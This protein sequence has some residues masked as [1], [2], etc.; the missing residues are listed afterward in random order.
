MDAVI[1]EDDDEDHAEWLAS[2]DPSSHAGQPGGKYALPVPPPPKYRVA[3]QAPHHLGAGAGAGVGRRR[4]SLSKQH[5]HGHGHGKKKHHQ[6]LEPFGM[7][8]DMRDVLEEII[9]MEKE[10][11][12]DENAMASDTESTSGPGA[13]VF[14]AVFDRP[15]RTP[16]P[17]P[18]G[19]RQP[20]LLPPGAPLRGAHRKSMSLHHHLAPMQMPDP[21]AYRPA[22]ARPPSSYGSSGYGFGHSSSLSESHTALYLATAS[23]ETASASDSPHRLKVRNSL[24]FTPEAAGPVIVP[25]ATPSRRAAGGRPS[26]S[27][28]MHHPTMSGWRFPAPGAGAGAGSGSNAVTPTKLTIDTQNLEPR[29]PTNVTRNHNHRQRHQFPA[30]APAVQP[31]TR[32]GAQMLWPPFPTSPDNEHQHHD[33]VRHRHVS[34]P[35]SGLTLGYLLGSGSGSGGGGDEDVD[36]MDLDH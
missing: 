29:T 36:M 22:P 20:S 10:F 3:Q 2:S 4:P 26:H 19:R 34:P 6:Q 32:A 18:E 24:T 11:V 30:A 13:G 35:D 23:P 8:K 7:G 12:I 33:A 28:T 25:G 17:G 27:P 14:T 5:P 15:P 1:M 9:Q 31:E 21:A 16:S